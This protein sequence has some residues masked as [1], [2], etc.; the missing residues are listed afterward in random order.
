MNPENNSHHLPSL[1][2]EHSSIMSANAFLPPTAEELV[3]LLHL[4]PHPEGGFFVE[5]Y[6]SGSVP[7]ASQGQTNYDVPNDDRDAALVTTTGRQDRR[8]DGNCQRNALTSIYFCP[9][10]RSPTQPLVQN[11]SDHAH[12]YQGGLPIRYH[13]YDPFTKELESVVLGPDVQNGHVMQFFVKGGRWKCGRIVQDYNDALPEGSAATKAID[14]DYTLLAEAVGPG[15]D[16][17][18]FHFVQESELRSVA[19]G[20]DNEKEVVDTLRPFLHRQ[21]TMDEIGQHYTD[22]EAQEALTKERM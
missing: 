12:Y 19:A 10:L 2:T 11:D 3:K 13:V 9:T 1:S 22:K 5:T 20:T 4:I 16:F 8:P 6:R 21:Q 7:M 15:F 18:D 17:Y 14:A